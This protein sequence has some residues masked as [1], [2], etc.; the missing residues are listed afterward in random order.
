MQIIV[1]YVLQQGGCACSLGDIYVLLSFISDAFS[2]ISKFVTCIF[3]C[4]ACI[5]IEPCLCLLRLEIPKKVSKAE[6][7]IF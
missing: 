5:T 1:I 3:L 7:G 4:V 2:F 6:I